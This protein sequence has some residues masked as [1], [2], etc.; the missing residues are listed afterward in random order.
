MKNFFSALGVITLLTIGCIYKNQTA[1]VMKNMDDI[2][3]HIKEESEK[4]EE[5]P[6]EA[7]IEN[8]KVI[9]GIAGRKIN[10]EKS[11]R[12][13]KNVGYFNE[14]LLEYEPIYPTFVLK[15]NLNNYIIKGNKQKEMVSFIFKIDKNVS[16]EN[17]E[18][19]LNIAKVKKVLFTFFLDGYWFE[20][21]NDFVSEIARLKHD[22]G[23]L[24][25][26]GNYKDSSFLWMNT[27][28]KKITN[29]KHSYCYLEEEKKEFL[30]ICALHQNYTI[31]PSLII[32]NNPYITIKEKLEK[33][34]IVTF[35]ITNTLIKELPSILSYIQNKGIKEVTLQELLE[36]TK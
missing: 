24:S 14:N 22:L 36:E 18:E 10:I 21:N 5:K 33:G 11:Y 9:P 7:K 13:M 2:M 31:Q 25:Y 23:N 34:D 32:T 4:Y 19:L 1:T 28:I 27:I 12:A 29:R 6:V 3:V 8:N 26:N 15:E 20:E 16:L 35:K 30:D 17:I